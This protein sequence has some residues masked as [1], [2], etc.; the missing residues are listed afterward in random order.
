MPATIPPAPLSPPQPPQRR[1]RCDQCW[2]PAGHCCSVSGP[3]GDHLARYIAAAK[4]GLIQRG[5]LAAIV[6]AMTVI[7]GHV[8]IIE[9]AA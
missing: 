2:A 9:A 4:L 7:A 8:M 3:P 1:I 6:A 5:Q